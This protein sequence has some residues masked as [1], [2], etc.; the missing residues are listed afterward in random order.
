MSEGLL[1]Q[2]LGG[3]NPSDLMGG[4][5]HVFS[6][7]PSDSNQLSTRIMIGP[8]KFYGD[9]C[10]KGFCNLLPDVHRY[11][12]H[13]EG[14]WPDPEDPLQAIFTD[15]GHGDHIGGIAPLLMAGCVL[16]PIYGTPMTLT[17]LR[18]DM[19]RYP[20]PPERLPRLI[21]LHPR[22][23]LTIGSLTVEPVSMSHSIADNVGYV[24]EGGGVR[25]FYTS[26]FK[27]DRTVSL[28]PATDI[29]RIMELAED[30]I[31]VLMIDCESIAYPGRARA[32]KEV[33]DA[34]F[35][36]LSR[37]ADKRAVMSIYG[38]YQERHV[39]A[40]KAGLKA[41]RRVII[42]DDD[43]MELIEAVEESGRRWQDIVG[44]DMT[45]LR[46]G[47][48]PAQHIPP[49]EQLILSS[50]TQVHEDS[51]LAQMASQNCPHFQS[52]HNTI[53][54]L[55]G[56]VWSGNRARVE[57]NIK[58]LQE[59]GIST[60][61]PDER[62]ELHGTGHGFQQDIAK[63]IDICRPGT[64]VPIHFQHGKYDPPSEMFGR[65]ASTPP[66]M[67]GALYVLEPH[68]SVRTMAEAN[69]ATYVGLPQRQLK[70]GRDLSLS[71]GY[72]RFSYR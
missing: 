69:A 22:Q 24:I 3:L 47:S 33:E 68:G 70:R 67:N 39:S 21:T 20:I 35:E 8:G 40:I 23:C 48:R 38:H 43:I 32:E 19:A 5:C 18:K 45:P 16:P 53:A 59:R 27:I 13:I 52:D 12:R 72:Q 1:W 46:L 6:H 65:T 49:H 61:T 28:G 29:A 51:L 36:E 66:G 44:Q 11:V 14:A 37:H 58:K 41:G 42:A 30:G 55:T 57:D 4:N 56:S 60:V 25:A 54:I 9:L 63:M 7:H 26:D 31:D 17:L 64:V 10:T 62:P 34:F 15:H 2:P 71:N 50:G